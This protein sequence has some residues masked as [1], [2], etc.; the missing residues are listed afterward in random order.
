METKYL[1]RFLKLQT[2]EAKK[3]FDFNGARLL[4]EIL[5]K[6]EIKTA[7]GLIISAPSDHVRVTADAAQAVMAIVLMTGTGYYD[8]DGKPVDME[9]Q[10]GNVVMVNEFGLRAFST[11]PGLVDYT[12]NSLA[13][14]TESEIQMRFK[15]VE[16]YLQYEAILNG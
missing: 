16:D 10:V 11:F 2:D 7:S 5:P 6:R 3:L 14:T 4:L 8:D 9:T 1:N 12:K 13:I 15:T